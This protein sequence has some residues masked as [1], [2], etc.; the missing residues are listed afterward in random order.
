MPASETAFEVM[1]EL[2]KL[3]NAIEFIDLT[4]DDIESK[5]NYISLIKRC[6]EIDK[7]IL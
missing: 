1:N 6:D 2:G 7:K 3:D 5:K 4:K